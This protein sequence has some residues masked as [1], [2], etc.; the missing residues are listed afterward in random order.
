MPIDPEV[1]AA[2]NTLNDKIN[3]VRDNA[4]QALE[5]E[6]EK[7]RDLHARFLLLKD[8][9][10]NLKPRFWKLNTQPPRSPGPNKRSQVTGGN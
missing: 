1:Q 7:R 3:S 9:L 2:L 10:D 6:R 5:Q 4:A 8:K